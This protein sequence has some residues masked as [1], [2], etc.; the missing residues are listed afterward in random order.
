MLSPGGHG[1]WHR[2]SAAAVPSPCPHVSRSRAVTE[3]APYFSATCVHSVALPCS[4]RL[5][6]PFPLPCSPLSCVA[7]AALQRAGVGEEARSPAALRA[8]AQLGLPPTAQNCCTALRGS[9]QLQEKPKLL[10]HTHMH[11]L[12]L[13][14]VCCKG[15]VCLGLRKQFDSYA[16]L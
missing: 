1:R 5:L 2:C 6:F 12:Y 11:N 13:I 3:G 10:L 15:Q 7:P 9:A 14:I 16:I 8:G 4:A